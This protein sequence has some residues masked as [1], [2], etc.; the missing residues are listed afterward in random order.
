MKLHDLKKLSFL[1]TDLINKAVL[2]FKY[3]YLFK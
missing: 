1:K 2:K 3:S